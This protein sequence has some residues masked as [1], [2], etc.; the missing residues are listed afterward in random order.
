MKKS[1]FF[2]FFVMAVL[3]AFVTITSCKDYE[4]DIS[5]LNTDLAA[6][7]SDA[8]AKS[9]LAALQTQLQSSITTTASD[10]AAAKA[11]LAT[12]QANSATQAKIDAAKAEILAIAVKTET[13]TAMKTQVDA[14][15][16]TLKGD[17]AKAPTKEYVNALVALTDS[18]ID[19][20]ALAL[21][22]KIANLEAILKVADGK[23]QVL[24]GLQSQ[25][26]AQLAEITANKA[27]IEA[28]KADLLAKY[29]EV[30]AEIAALKADLDNLEANLAALD[31][32]VEGYKTALEKSI[33]DLRADMN[34]LIFD[35]FD[36]L[37]KRV[38]SLTFIPD[39]SSQ[40]GTPQLPVTFLGEWYKPEATVQN[41]DPDYRS[42]IMLTPYKGI[43]YVKY[44]V[45]PSNATLADFEV[46][47]LLNKSSEVL[48]RSSTGDPL[49]KAVV[50]D[51]TLN[52]GI[53]TVPVLI[54]A[55]LYDNDDFGHDYRLA[56]DIDNGDDQLLYRLY[57]KNFGVA[58]QVK[59][60]NMEEDDDTERLVVSSAYINT[61]L[62]LMFARIEAFDE[63]DE[64]YELGDRWQDRLP[65]RM[66]DNIIN[67][68]YRR[69]EIEL[70]NGYNRNT[71]KYESFSINLNDYVQA[72][73]N[74]NHTW[75]LL[76]EFGYDNIEDH[77]VYELISVDNEGVDQSSYVTLNSATGVISVKPAQGGGANQAAVGRTPVV[78]AK[79]VK[80]GKVYAAGYIKILITETVDNSPIAFEFNLEDYMIGCD[81]E[82]QFTNVDL[83]ETD[84]DQIF[85]HP[86][87]MLGKDAFFEAYRTPEDILTEVISDPAAADGTEISF[88]WNIEE[89]TQGQNLANYI[90]GYVT[91]TAPAGVYKVKT[92]L[93]GKGI[94]PDI[95]IIWTINVKLPAI[96]LTANT[97]ILA[98]GKIVV[99]PTII[100]Q[101][102]KTSA[103]YEALL[104]NAFM[105]ESGEFVFKPLPADCDEYLTPYFVFT[106]AVP[107]GYLIST[108]GKRIFKGTNQAQDVPANLAAR[109]ERDPIDSLK[110]FVR[111]NAETPAVSGVSIGNYPPLSEAAKGLVGKTVS[112]QPRGYINGAT[113][114]YINLYN[115]FNV[116]FV[117]PLYLVLPTN[118]SVYDQANNGN[119]VYSLN[120]YDPSVLKDWNGKLLDVTTAAGRALINHYEA[121]GYASAPLD[122][123]YEN[124]GNTNFWAGPPVPG[125]EWYVTGWMTGYW[126]IWH[127][128]STTEVFTSPFQFDLAG[129]K[130]SIKPD[131][132]IDPNNVSY[133]IPA[134]MN[135]KINTVANTGTT[136]IIEGVPTTVPAEYTFE[137]DNGSTGAIQNAFKVSVPVSVKHKWGTL[138]STLVIS[139]NPG[140]GPVPAPA[141]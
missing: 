8:V 116:E 99:N 114:N 67:E 63:E 87:V 84:F 129:M 108:D 141:P 6:M 62:S 56:K 81:S 93:K 19:S 91:N 120:M 31:T 28:T 135:L 92:T 38:T 86:R 72:I 49:M 45:S 110:L 10:L 58:L 95:E 105:H 36:S 61:Q 55:D 90:N 77:F 53:L 66:L 18:Q 128:E 94:T 21:S 83:S 106:G 140:A 16:A 122:G 127:P 13:L 85:N 76:E 15:L 46:V 40:D 107:T 54:H 133:P 51:V 20:V 98:N 24:D 42:D 57:D 136:T 47:G 29:N 65:S 102:G 100:E 9:E 113:Y 11:S 32:K 70:W 73:G 121:F 1:Y 23:S 115:A 27:A 2:K 111:L 35:V 82:Y 41:W 33:A 75:R 50:E 124:T 59:N 104:N 43:T 25:L 130:S 14:E 78:L 79:V 60:K 123:Y 7:K 74:F 64:D 117:T 89:P 134:G 3:A 22:A 103:A 12:L 52:N 30:K 69:P 17:L 112:V 119:N 71:Q 132:S 96:S 101:N 126:A 138:K 37:D 80:N 34:N 26:T 44:H 139:V 118:A 68:T 88:E 131:G 48:F 125:A 39:F 109:I 5:R 137:W 4:D 97:A